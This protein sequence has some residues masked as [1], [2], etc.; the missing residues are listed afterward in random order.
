M[1][2]WGFY[3]WSYINLMWCYDILLNVF[4]FYIVNNW[5]VRLI[6]NNNWLGIIWVNIYIIFIDYIW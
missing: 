2:L 1:F 5:D 6:E 4:V 3:D